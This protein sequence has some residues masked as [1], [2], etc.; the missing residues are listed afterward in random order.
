MRLGGKRGPKDLTLFKP[1]DDLKSFVKTINDNAQSLNSDY[2]QIVE[3]F[4]QIYATQFKKEDGTVS[5]V[6]LEQTGT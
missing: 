3:E 5:E 2:K 4:S 6:Q 1:C